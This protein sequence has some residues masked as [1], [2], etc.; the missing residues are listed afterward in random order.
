VTLTPSRAAALRVVREARTRAGWG[1][2]LLG[3]A[4]TAFGLSERDA[5]F[6]TRL[7]YGVLASEGTLDDV[8]DRYIDRP[9]R[10][11]PLVRDALRVAAYELLFMRTP[12][13]VAVHQGVESVRSV[14][15]RAAG[16]ANAVLRRVADD[17]ST[18]PWGDPD[19][20]DEA[21]AR[22]TMHP[23]WLVRTL[24]ED[25][26]PELARTM[27]EA[28]NEP[29]PLFLAHNPF[30][31]SFSDLVA[32]LE[33]EG[34]APHPC[35]PEGCIRA[36]SPSAAVRSSA[37]EEGSCVVADA[38]AQFVASLAA[39]GPDRVGVELAAG[40]GTK[41]LLMQ[42][43]SVRAGGPAQ[44][45]SADVHDYKIALL[46]ERLDTL[47]VPGV[48]GVAADTTDPGSVDALG[49]PSSADVVL[50]DAPCSGI[51]TLRRHPEKRWRLDPASID[52][53]AVLGEGMLGTAARLVRPGGFV[54]YSTCTVTDRENRAVVEGFLAGPAG[55]G[56]RTA[57]VAASVPAGW[58]RFVTRE[59][60]FRSVPEPDGPDGHFAAVLVRES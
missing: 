31:A 7:A 5:A 27:L 8:L 33:H 29:A 19:T 28:N 58:D 34:V 15:R 23:V 51:G 30:A 32:S 38:A 52:E 47:H 57:S 26:G 20:D 35:Q 45:V 39:P 53:L 24:K 10:V 16:L 40:R 37:L 59:G 55:K 50:I 48:R 1:H 9:S 42:A 41:T 17:A 54:V 14:E 13:R 2:E 12:H 44:I 21:L 3:P 56:F 11:H 25:L 43:G 18:F 60:W 46:K 22:M 6:T 49:G 4:L 36:A